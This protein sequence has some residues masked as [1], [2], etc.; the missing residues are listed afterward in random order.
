LPV[1][2]SLPEFSNSIAKIFGVDVFHQIT[3]QNPYHLLS[4]VPPIDE[5]LIPCAVLKWN[6][7]KYAG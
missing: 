6:L 3:L 4:F 7:R 5:I 1:L 2:R